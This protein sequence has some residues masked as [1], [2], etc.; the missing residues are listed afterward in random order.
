MYIKNIITT[1]PPDQVDETN[2]V[3]LTLLPIPLCENESQ[4]CT[5]THAGSEGSTTLLNKALK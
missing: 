2:Q 1:P 3:L 5:V 4:I